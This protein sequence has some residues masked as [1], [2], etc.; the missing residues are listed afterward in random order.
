MLNVYDKVWIMENNLPTERIVYAVGESMVDDTSER[1]C[2]TTVKY[3]LVIRG[4]Y[5]TSSPVRYPMD[6]LY[7]TKEDLVMSLLED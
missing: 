6:D 3:A 7:T 2:F 4:I 1:E 5:D